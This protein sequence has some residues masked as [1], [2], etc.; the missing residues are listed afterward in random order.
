MQA[1]DESTPFTEKQ[2]AA[3]LYQY[4]RMPIL[5]YKGVRVPDE[6]YDEMK[7]LAEAD[8][9][10]FGQT[11]NQ[12]LLTWLNQVEELIMREKERIEKKY[13]PA[14]KKSGKQKVDK[15]ELRKARKKAKQ[16]K[17]ANRR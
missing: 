4:E 2:M 3:V 11:K 7:K 15:D 9:G 12:A 13:N 16:N 17:K 8:H 5:S 10:F 14:M 6:F 1:F